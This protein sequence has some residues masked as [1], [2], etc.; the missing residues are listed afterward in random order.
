MGFRS[1]PVVLELASRIGRSDLF[2]WIEEEARN[3]ATLGRAPDGTVTIG[4][5]LQR[6]RG[7]TTVTP[8]RMS[9][10]AELRSDGDGFAIAFNPAL[11]AEV[12]RFS[13]AHEIG[14][15]LWIG[16]VPGQTLRNRDTTSGQSGRTI[17]MLCDYFAGALLMPR[18]DV[19]GILRSH[20][21]SQGRGRRPGSRGTV[22]PGVSAGIGTDV[23]GATSHRGVATALGA[24]AIIMG[25]RSGAGSVHGVESPLVGGPAARGRGVGDGVV[26]NWVRS[27]HAPDN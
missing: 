23:P 18:D 22:S 2:E 1:S 4:R 21:E 25:H 26:R 11:S 5:T 16:S 14:H 8:R 13:I 20:R 15:T 19:Q 12:Q 17:E 24:T 7:V 3:L 10:R 6:A 27:P 9:A